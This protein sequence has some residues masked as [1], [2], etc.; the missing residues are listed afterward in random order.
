MFYKSTFYKSMFYKSTFYRSTFYKS[1][2]Y[3]STFYKSAFNKSTFYKSM[4]YKST[5]YKSMFYKSTFYK[6]SFY[7]SMFYK[8]MADPDFELRLGPSFGLLALPAFLPSV[9]SSFFTQ[10]KGGLG[11]SPRSATANP[12]HV[13]QIHSSPL[14]STSCFTICHRLLF[15]EAIYINI[16]LRSLKNY[17]VNPQRP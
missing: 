4:F 1:T 17:K 15:T 6:S 5:F 10:N 9:I 8:S 7:K 14:H 12:L 11:P 2:F 3:K 16:F 13:L